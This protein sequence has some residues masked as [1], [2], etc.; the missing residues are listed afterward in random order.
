MWKGHLD[1]L[2][3]AKSKVAKVEHHPALPYARIGE[4]MA[5]LF[6]RDGAAAGAL[7]F[8]ILG[9]GTWNTS[10]VSIAST[11]GVRTMG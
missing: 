1:H 10:P 8:T 3:P 2:L 4:F 7:R 5:D 6:K 11:G 9:S